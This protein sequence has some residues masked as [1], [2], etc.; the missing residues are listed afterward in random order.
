MS[1]LPFSPDLLQKAKTIQLLIL[2]VDGV[3]TNGQLGLDDDLTASKSFH[4]RDGFGIRQLLKE[5]IQV[6]VITG[7]ESKLVSE[8]IRELKIPYLFQNSPDKLPIFKK[9][10]AD[11]NLQSHQVAYMGDDLIDLP[12]LKQVGL[13]AAPADAY[14][15]VKEHTDFIAH[16]SGGNGAVR[17]LCDLLLA[18]RGRL[19]S[20]CQ[21]FLK[22]G[23]ELPSEQRY[24]PRA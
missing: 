17:E 13:S 15:F 1:Y 8:R 6:A 11:L 10:L 5:N 12:V 22:D 9:L 2:D 14:F 4:V 19:E 7:R 20:I 16:H 21:Q 23:T 3:L 24:Q 18:G